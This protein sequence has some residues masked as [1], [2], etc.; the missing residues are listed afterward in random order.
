MPEPSPLLRRL[1]AV[2]AGSALLGLSGWLASG[3]IRNQA[4]REALSA[5]AAVLPPDRYDNDPL[6]DRIRVIDEAALGSAQ[7]MPVLRARK[8]GQPAALVIEAIVPKAYAGPVRLQI[9]VDRRGAVT[10]VRVL[11]HHETPG[12]GDRFETD[13]GEWLAAIRGRSLDTTPTARWTVRKDGGD[14]DQFSGATT[15]PRAIL[16]RIAR[17]LEFVKAHRE[18]LFADEADIP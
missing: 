3:R 15:T 5:L 11:E 13:S 2:M 16:E 1:F 18:A 17:V 10:G 8:D 4:H 6:A 7:P 14:F 12:L 9:G